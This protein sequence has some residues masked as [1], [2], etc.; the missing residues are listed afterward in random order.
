MKPMTDPIGSTVQLGVA[1]VLAMRENRRCVRRPLDLRLE[2]FMNG[3]QFTVEACRIPLIAT[4]R[5]AGDE[6][7]CKSKSIQWFKRPSPRVVPAAF[8]AAGNSFQFEF[9]AH[10]GAEKVHSVNLA[11][12]G[13]HLYLAGL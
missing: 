12:F 3:H 5:L 10:S 4:A 9:S 11:G 2:Q 8:E 1:Q 7:P 13:K 6:M